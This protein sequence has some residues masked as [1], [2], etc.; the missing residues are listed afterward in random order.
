[1]YLELDSLLHISLIKASLT[2]VYP[3][4]YEK[5]KIHKDIYRDLHSQSFVVVLENK[6]CMYL[7]AIEM[8]VSF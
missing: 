1:M 8:T 3:Y 7:E 4:V 6:K 5:K 2:S